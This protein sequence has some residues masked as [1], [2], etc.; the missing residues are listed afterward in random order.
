[1]GTSLARRSHSL[2]G[3]SSTRP[4][5]RMAALEAMVVKV[6]ICATRSDPYLSVT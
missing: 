1:M 6:M 4:T 3:T 2:S 5:S